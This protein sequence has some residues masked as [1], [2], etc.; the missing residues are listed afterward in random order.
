MKVIKFSKLKSKDLDRILNRSVGNYKLFY[1]V[2]K[3]I[4]DDVK[5]RGDQA[6]I[7]YEKKFGARIATLKVSEN[8]IDMAF[9]SADPKLI[10]AFKQSIKNITKVAKSQLKSKEKTVD[11]EKGIKVWREWRPIEKVGLYIPGGKA[12]YPSSLLMTA[13]PAQ[14]AGSLEILVATPPN[15][16]GKINEP[17]LIA[18][19]LLGIK[20]IFKTGGAQ[21]IAAFA[22]GTESIPKVY[23][24]FGAGNSYVTAAKQLVFGDV[25]IDMPAGPS[26]VFIIADETADPKFIAADL[27][28]DCEHGEDSA[29]ILITISKKIADQ[30]VKEIDKQ[31]KNLSTSKRAQTS[32]QK[33]GLIAVTD[34]MEKAIN[35]AN[36]YAPEHL[37]IMTKNP[38]KV[39]R[40][41]NNAGSV[42]LGS[43]TCKGSGDY[44]T[45]ANHILPTGQNAK[46]FSA[47]SV[48]SFGKMI[49]FQ[50][51]TKEGLS[52]IRNTI[53]KF[54]EVEGLPAHGYSATVRF[55][56][57]KNV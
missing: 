14:V 6:V 42:F 15:S 38:V 27:I 22:F 5:F 45:G 10:T 12:V 19:K 3:K 34:S 8:E 39:A 29:G 33:N 2:V 21:A 36:Y 18:A 49:E 24:I 48:D 56:G 16:E 52:K 50:E 54:S 20:N 32:L 30:T 57:D 31:L 37:E 9:Q 55:K 23:K 17:I 40:K 1:P 51:V 4:L 43:Y 13:I 25:N 28:A 44:A 11:T 47:L 26:E 53:E 46:S 7:D 35:F 41:I